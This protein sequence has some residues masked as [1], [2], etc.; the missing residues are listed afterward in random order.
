ME[1]T[2][3]AYIHRCSSEDLLGFLDNCVLANE[4]KTHAHIIPLIL[5]LMEDRHVTVP[6]Y[7]LS[8]WN[9]FCQNS[10]ESAV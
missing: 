9:E 10:S 7:I 1:H 3:Q 8:S 4:W 2:V 5:K 6:E